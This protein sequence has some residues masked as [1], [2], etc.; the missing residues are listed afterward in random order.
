MILSLSCKAQQIQ[1]P[2]LDTKIIGTWMSND[3]ATYKIIFSNNGDYKSYINNVLSSVFTYEITTQ[4]NGQ[5]LTENYDIFLKVIDTED[6]DTYCHL[7]N[8]IHTDANGLTTLSLTSEGGKL[9][10]YTKQ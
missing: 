8:G 6:L 1:V 9:W 7:L 10:L 3:D 2:N 5:T 4:C